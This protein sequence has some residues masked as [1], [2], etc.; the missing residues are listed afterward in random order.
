MK[1]SVRMNEQIANGLKELS[2]KDGVARAF[3]DHAAQRGQ[4]N[5][6]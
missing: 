2:H 5:Y 6:S 4:A 1:E 3:L